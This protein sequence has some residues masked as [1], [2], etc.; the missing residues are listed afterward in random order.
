[1]V[2]YFCGVENLK[3]LY[4]CLLMNVPYYCHTE[5]KLGQDY[6][7]SI[8]RALNCSKASLIEIADTLVIVGNK[9][10]LK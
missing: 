3:P 4:L 5:Q 10:I 8:E 1:M 6:C 9:I 2:L 7:A